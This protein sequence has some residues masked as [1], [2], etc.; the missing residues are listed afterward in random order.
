MKIDVYLKDPDGFSDSVHEAAVASLK[1]LPL[2]AREL[3]AVRDAREEEANQFLRRWVEDGE[4]IGIVF[5]TEAG[6]A[7]VVERKR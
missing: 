4:Y 1:G 5:D 2:S 7:T 3:E 6:T